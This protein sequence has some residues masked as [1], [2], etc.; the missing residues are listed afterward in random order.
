M[1]KP[2]SLQIGAKTKGRKHCNIQKTIRTNL[3]FHQTKIQRGEDRDIERLS[4]FHK[5]SRK[6]KVMFKIEQ[7][8][9]SEVT[10]LQNKFVSKFNSIADLL[11]DI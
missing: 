11:R 7:S 9:P 6:K 5:I 10:E 2:T 8:D 1:S 3:C 4:I